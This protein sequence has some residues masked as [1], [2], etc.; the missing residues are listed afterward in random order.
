MNPVG[1]QKWI[2]SRRQV[3][4]VQAPNIIERFTDTDVRFVIRDR[5]T[6]FAAD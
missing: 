3:I 1:C 6:K 4:F 5:D 2:N